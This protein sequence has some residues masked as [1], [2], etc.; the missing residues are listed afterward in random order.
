MRKWLLSLVV[1]SLILVGCQQVEE[2]TDSATEVV[3]IDSTSES[4]YKMI[5]LGESELRDNYYTKFSRTDDLVTIGRGLQ[6]LSS[7]YFSMSSYYM[8]EGQYLSLD[9]R[10]EF[11][12]YYYSDDHPYSLELAKK[13]SLEGI[14]G[15]DMVED[16]H[17][18]DY[19]KKS[20]NSYV[21]SG[22]SFAI[23]VDPKTTDDQESVTLTDKTVE[24]YAEDA[25]EKLYENLQEMDDFEEIQ[26]IPILIAVYRRTDSS[27]SSYDGNYFL[28]SYCNGSVGSFEEVDHQT[29]L[30]T[31]DE[32]EELDP[33]TYEEFLVIKSNLKEASY[34]SSSI[35]GYGKYIDGV[36]QSM[37]IEA[38]INI[39]TYTEILYLTTVIE[40]NI[41]SKFSSS[42]TIKVYVY[43]QDDLVA[44][45]IKNIGE[46]PQTT[47]VE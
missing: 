16:I 9:N 28:E 31:S 47:F 29:V 23:V 11:T 12:T 44:T 42:F 45:I 21:I 30:F 5:N 1:L 17:E 18:Q 20:G 37:K 14:S 38:H 4:Y 27:T 3:E 39:K 36:I 6:I 25:I 13:D 7:D 22:I 19:Y 26:D 32:A 15:L 24:A 10:K 43:S 33:T 41:D 2:T 8:S 34:E 46:D 35:V 40:N